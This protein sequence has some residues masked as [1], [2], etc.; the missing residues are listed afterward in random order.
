M[1]LTSNRKDQW[2]IAA[3]VLLLFAPFLGGVHLFDWDEINFAEIAREMVLSGNYLSPQLNFQPF[4]EKPPLFMWL[5]AFSMQL[6][7]IGEYGARFPNVLAGLCTLLMIYDIGFRLHG[8]RMAR[9]WVIAFVGSTLPSFYFKSGLIDPWFNFFIFSGLWFLIKFHWRTNDIKGSD[10]SRNPWTYLAVAALFTG[11]GVLTKGPVAFLIT[12]IC[13]AVY[14]MLKRFKWFIRP[15]SFLLFSLGVAL[16][17]GLWYGAEWLVNGPSFLIEFT[18]RQWALLTTPDAGH[19][20]F[21][22]YH[23]VVLLLG[24]FP[25]S[26]FALRSLASRS[27]EK[28]VQQDMRLWMIILLCVVLVLFSLVRSKIV[29]YSSLAYFPLT[30]L[31]ALALEKMSSKSWRLS[32][33]FRFSIALLGFLYFV[34]SV[35]LVALGRTPEW[36]YKLTASDPFARANLEAVV[37]WPL[38]AYLPSLLAL[39]L[40][41]AF[42]L[43]YHRRPV[44]A[45]NILFLGQA[46]WVQLALFFFIAR[47]EAISQRAH[48]EF[49][50]SVADEDAGKTTYKF[51]SYVP[52]FYGEVQPKAGISTQSH[53]RI[54]QLQRTIYV[55]VKEGRQEEF[56]LEWPDAEKLYSKNGF[57]FYRRAAARSE[58]P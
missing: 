53:G 56:E 55:S 16:V 51:K 58:Q 36:L 9:W 22:A 35:A 11:L 46:L 41:V 31:A 50:R 44:K 26:L 38:I 17:T 24:C 27:E 3:A 18:E 6:F 13:L 21:P 40:L 52:M 48:I 39:V 25:A 57:H 5:Q 10:L 29:H 8:Q 15:L 2:R 19:G 20:G 43:I 1:R 47:V 49:F 34:V 4:T 30:Y 28:G 7:G 32:P 37:D 45:L 23:F 33:F 12:G 54:L 14:W 42:Q